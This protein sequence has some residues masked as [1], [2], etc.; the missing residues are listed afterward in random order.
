MKTVSDAFILKIAKSVVTEEAA[1]LRLASAGL[2]KDLVRAARLLA[3]EAAAGRL[4]P[5]RISEETLR[6]QLYAPDV[7]DPDLIVRT[8][9]ELRISNFLL[10]QA[11]YSEWFITPVLWPDFGEAEFHA[12]L[13][14]YAAR[15]RRYG[16][17]NENLPGG[18]PA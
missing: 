5:D 16:R 7:P 3:T 1:A 9:G 4:R 17:V 13:A 8:S 15:D 14:A 6:A 11:A 2:G 12:A 18:K 10:W